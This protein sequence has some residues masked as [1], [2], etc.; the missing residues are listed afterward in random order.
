MSALECSAAIIHTTRKHICVISVYR[1]V[2]RN[3]PVS[4]DLIKIKNVCTNNNWELVIGGD[5]NAKHQ[6]WHNTT[7]CSAGRALAQW[8][9]NESV[10]HNL[11]MYCPT[12]YTYTN[13]RQTT[14]IDLF[15]TSSS[16]NVT[17]TNAHVIDYD[18]D[19]RAIHINVLL[20]SR[21][22]RN[23]PPTFLNYKAVNWDS[24]KTQL[25]R[26]VAHINIPDDNNLPSAVIDEKLQQITCAIQSTIDTIV[27]KT[28][29]NRSNTITLPADILDNIRY[30]K[31]LR[32]RYQ[33]NR[34]TAEGPLLK[35]QIR[36][37]TQLID[38]K[39]NSLRNKNFNETLAN[40][41][42]NNNTFKSI[43]ALSGRSKLT[44]I[45]RI[46][47]T[48]NGTATNSADIANL[49]GQH[50]EQTH[51]INSTHGD[52]VFTQLVNHQIA[53]DFRSHHPSCM[54]TAQAPAFSNA[55]WHDNLLV[56]R[57]SLIAI[58]KTRANK[59]SCGPDKI[60][61]VVL[62]KLPIN[63]IDKLVVIFNHL[64]N[65]AHFPQAWKHAIVVPIPKHGKPP[66]A[67][68]SYRPISL[69]SALSKIYEVA[70]K[71]K[72][73]NHCLL[74]DLLPDDQFAYRTGRATT[75]PLAIFKTDI[76]SQLNAKNPTI[77]CAIDVKS[78]FD[79]V[80]TQGLVYKLRE[81]FNFPV[82]L[83]HVI[84]NYLQNRTFE[85]RVGRAISRN[86]SI[87]AG[88]PQGGVL[89]A[90]LYIIYIAD[91]PPPPEHAQPI[92]RLQYADDMIV[93]AS[94]KNVI[95]SQDRI[96]HYLHT[97]HTHFNKWQITINT[98]KCEVITIIGKKKNCCN[99][100]K[101]HHTNVSIN[102]NNTPIPNVNHLKYLGVIFTS[103][104]SSIPHVKKTISKLHIAY[105]ILKPILSNH[106]LIPKVK[107]LCYKQLLR[108]II[109]YG[110]SSW[111]DLSSHQMENLRKLE[112]AYIRRCGN[113]RPRI[114]PDG[115]KHINNARLYRITGI[116]RIDR[117][118]TNS[119]VKLFEKNYTE[120]SLMQKTKAFDEDYH[121]TQNT[122][123]VPYYITHLHNTNQ[124][125]TNNKLLLYHIPHNTTST[126][127]TVYNNQQ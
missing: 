46:I 49:L 104:N 5:F 96:N 83:C 54:F 76:N 38:G 14:I 87:A 78:A 48:N 114:T 56:T 72:I 110:F 21:P 25:N 31:Y 82:H 24:F 32:R 7:I 103:D 26:R 61:N 17:S 90:L 123:H 47:T 125:Y 109:M 35:T 100:V 58:L 37:L 79:T 42:V 92:K 69:T 59:K 41:R 15:V 16:I 60:P 121:N 23:N 106:N 28:T 101:K 81:H 75:H 22:L 36:L 10:N 118:L 107:L 108:P 12:Q 88:V 43:K 116:N 94:A 11:S 98:S 112:R 65:N 9:I 102:I 67:A 1:S 105:S 70:I 52:P 34:L 89:S 44:T 27:P 71:S 86:F 19:H 85:V 63:C 95:N 53:T 66:D 77:A 127:H 73:D 111:C 40:I 97:I 45:S 8:F 3:T 57:S 124:L 126:R 50:F 91:I 51:L 120:C 93:Y 30:K 113:I 74:N 2:T 39:I 18:S 122:Y 6:L 119:T 117:E 99:F 33:R 13:G 55:T 68:T 80:W 29:M 115:I 20:T 4:H 84:R 62:R 64:F